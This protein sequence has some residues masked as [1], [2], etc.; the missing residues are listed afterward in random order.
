MAKGSSIADAPEGAIPL[1]PAMAASAGETPLD[2]MMAEER[3]TQILQ[4]SRRRPNSGASE[5]CSRSRTAQKRQ[6]AMMGTKL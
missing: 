6:R 3:R 4:D 1:V 2:G 5:S